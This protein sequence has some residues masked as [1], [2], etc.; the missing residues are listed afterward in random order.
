MLNSANLTETILINKSQLETM[1]ALYEDS[2]LLSLNAFVLFFAKLENFSV[3]IYTSKTDQ[4]KVVFQGH[5]FE[6]DL[7]LFSNKK[8]TIVHQFKPHYG[9]DEVGTGDF[10]GPV[11]VTASYVDA[12]LAD[13][14]IQFGVKDSKDLTDDFMRE[15]VTKIQHKVTSVTTVVTPEKYKTLID[16]GYNLNAIKARMHHHALITLRGKVTKKHPMII[17][18]FASLKNFLGYIHDLPA[19][20]QL[21]LEVKAENKYLAVAMSSILARVKFLD[22]MDT[23][24][25]TYG[26]K[27]PLGASVYVEKFALNFAKKHGIDVLKSITKSNFKT[28]TRIEDALSS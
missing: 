7:S 15:L 13:E 2:K 14:L 9:S 4:H 24:S 10:F 21:V 26:I 18:Q 8:T 1:I 17:D 19:I 28:L 3:T 5:D 12:A 16:K 20:P 11:V 6:S 23:L 27:I 22:Y 25:L